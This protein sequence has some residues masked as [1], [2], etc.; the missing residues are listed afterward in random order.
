MIERTADQN[1]GYLRYAPSKGQLHSVRGRSLPQPGEHER[2][3]PMTLGG[4]GRDRAEQL[5][6]IGEHPEVAEPS[7]LLRRAGGA[8]AG[9]G[10]SVVLEVQ[11]CNRGR[12]KVP[13]LCGRA[14]C[15]APKGCGPA[16]VG[17]VRRLAAICRSRQGEGEGEGSRPAG[18]FRGRGA[19]QRSWPGIRQEVP[20]CDLA[21]CALSLALGVAVGIE[22]HG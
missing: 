3:L 9:A 7:I 22:Q 20:A 15:V 11:V 10:L 14:F 21:G 18:R 4:T 6:L 12:L 1:G 5:L 2:R 8:A 17:D 13:S 19:W 16:W